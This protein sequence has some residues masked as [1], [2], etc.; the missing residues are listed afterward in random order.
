MGEWENN[1]DKPNESASRSRK[2]TCSGHGFCPFRSQAVLSEPGNADSS[3]PGE[4]YQYGAAWSLQ[5][6]AYPLHTCLK[7]RGDV[8]TKW[9]PVEAS[10][11]M[12][13]WQHSRKISLFLLSS[14]KL[15]ACRKNIDFNY[16]ISLESLGII[17][18]N[19]T[20]IQGCFTLPVDKWN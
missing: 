2:F 19:I 8:F 17:T 6:R 3:G 7:T 14:C 16:K 12:D 5:R 1:Y 18:N 13:H 20:N 15:Y 10:P 4:A 9:S 11:K